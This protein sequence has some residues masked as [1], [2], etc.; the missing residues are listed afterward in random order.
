VMARFE[1]QTT[2]IQVLTLPQTLEFTPIEMS[3][4]L[5][6]DAKT[7][8]RIIDD[9]VNEKLNQLRIRPSE[10]CDDGDFIRR[11]TIDI[12]GLLPT[13]EE[14]NRF[15][16]DSAP[17]K[18]DRVVDD[19]LA[20]DEF[21]EIWA[22]KFAQLLMIK[23]NNIVSGKA[24]YLFST[25]LS[26]KL[27]DGEPI[28]EIV[29]EILTASGGTLENPPT[30]Y[31]EFQRNPNAASEHVAQVFMGIRMQ[32]AQCHNHPFD[33]W[34]MDD[35]YGFAAFFGQVGRKQ[36]EDYRERI[37]F[38][39]GGEVR[40]PVTNQRVAPRFLGAER[41]DFSSA[42]HRGKPRREVVA[43]WLTSPENPYFARSV[44]NRIWA[45]F[46]GSGVIDPVDDVRVSNP[47]SNPALLDELARRL[48]EYE[49]DFRRLVRDICTS[50]AYQRSSRANESNAHDQRNYARAAVRRI[51]AEHLLDC[52]S[53]VTGSPDKF[54][55]LPR[56][57]RAVQIAD[58]RTSNY[59]LDAFG[60]SQR[61][62]GCAC[63]ASTGPSLSQA[64][65]LING[66]TIHGK[67][68]RGK[69]VRQWWDE[70]EG[71]EL[72][73]SKVID[74]IYLAS[75]SRLPTASEGRDLMAV[76]DSSPDPVQGLED[77]FWSVLNGREFLF[78]H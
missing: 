23:S 41:P 50:D 56:G 15:V 16:A 26:D 70:S 34:T 69:R 72:R 10:R 58:G 65:H 8:S 59:F 43:D 22:M 46:M 19:L 17:D 24:A 47:P 55:G 42:P 25:W 37:V 60:R 27:I 28:D 73:I 45:H 35:Y 38:D 33:R 62:S 29:K 75:L 4:G 20:R 39:R 51:P 21:A 31:Y 13:I 52:I 40:H 61:T 63:E 76:V 2:G 49:F 64:L 44:A 32:C 48:V 9:L 12:T 11:V 1:T 74:K 14:V 5:A 30:N 66:S 3:M 6:G 78:N 77:V 57:A 36:A 18:R 67:I 68:S 53:Q 71:E 7:P 54:R